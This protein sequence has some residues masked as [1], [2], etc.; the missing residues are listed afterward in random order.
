MLAPSQQPQASIPS[1]AG[2]A[3]T[4]PRSGCM[5]IAIG[6]AQMLT[7]LGVKYVLRLVS[8]LNS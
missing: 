7:P 4:Q 1:F 6:A 5:F 2:A 8:T 3:P